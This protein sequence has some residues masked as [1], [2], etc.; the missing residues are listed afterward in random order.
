MTEL[1]W[2]R[3]LI[4]LVT[5]IPVLVFGTDWLGGYRWF[6]PNDK[7]WA[8]AAALLFTTVC[9]LVGLTR[10]ALQREQERLEREGE[11]KAR[12]MDREMGTE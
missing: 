3:R 7:T 4:V 9:S 8:L 5:G 2:P 6:W 1:S 12:Q 10:E 11:E